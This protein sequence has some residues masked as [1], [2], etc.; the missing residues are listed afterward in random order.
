LAWEL[1]NE[2]E[3]VDATPHSLIGVW[4]SDRAERRESETLKE[5]VGNSD[6]Y[7]RGAVLGG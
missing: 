5:M 4:E 2:V 6:E 3:L 1:E 7:S